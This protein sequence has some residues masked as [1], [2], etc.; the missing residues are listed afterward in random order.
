[1][2]GDFTAPRRSIDNTEQLQT[3]PSMF[4]EPSIAN[5]S[6]LRPHPNTPG[7]MQRLEIVRHQTP[8]SRRHRRRRPPTHPSINRRH[9][10][11]LASTPPPPPPYLVPITQGHPER[12]YTPSAVLNKLLLSF[13][14]LRIVHALLPRSH[15][16]T[17]T[18]PSLAR[19]CDADSRAK[20]LSIYFPPIPTKRPK[21]AEI[22]YPCARLGSPGRFEGAPRMTRRERWMSNRS[23]RRLRQDNHASRSTSERCRF[24]SPR[25]TIF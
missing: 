15:H 25:S 4:D 9:R 19:L 13:F 1:M 23:T 10:K 22:Y 8:S 7:N 21:D 11:D 20:L 17:Q 16:P 3:Q 18:T 2:A 12:P 5:A 14:G 6:Q 24:H